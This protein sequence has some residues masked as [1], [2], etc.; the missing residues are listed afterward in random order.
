MKVKIVS[1]KCKG[2]PISVKVVKFQRG[3]STDINDKSR[4][5]LPLKAI[6]YTR[7]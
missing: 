7:G 1:T 4:V 5:Y 6:K 2:S 3:H